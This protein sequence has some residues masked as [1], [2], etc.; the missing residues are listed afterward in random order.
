MTGTCPRPVQCKKK[1]PRPE[2]ERQVI[3]E[4]STTVGAAG[5]LRIDLDHTTHDPRRMAGTGPAR[6]F[7]AP[8]LRLLYIR[9]P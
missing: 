3:G 6:E 5:G 8:P 2:P 4:S 7:V 1:P 9:T